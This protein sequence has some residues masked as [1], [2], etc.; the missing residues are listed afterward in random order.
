M[1][2]YHLVCFFRA[3]AQI[4]NRQGLGHNDPKELQKKYR[5]FFHDYVKSDNENDIVFSVDFTNEERSVLHK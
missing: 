4:M 2:K 1:R 3:S 5:Q